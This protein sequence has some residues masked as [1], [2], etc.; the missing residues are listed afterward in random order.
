MTDPGW[1]DR[2]LATPFRDVPWDPADKPILVTKDRSWPIARLA[3]PVDTDV[4][5][6]VGIRDRE[7]PELARWLRAQAIRFY[8]MRVVDLTP[9]AAIQGLQHLCIA[10]NTKVQSIEPLRAFTDLRTLVLTNTPKVRSLA[11]LE[12]L[13]ALR[14]F[15]CSGF[16]FSGTGHTIDTLAPVSGL[17]LE[18]IRLTNC[19]VLDDGLRPLARIRTLR[20]LESSNQFETEDYAYL[21]VHLPQATCDKFAPYVRLPRPLEDGRDVMVVGRRKPFLNSQIDAARL[22][23]YEDRFRA[24]Q[25]QFASAIRP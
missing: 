10:W 22:R 2:L 17:S 21:S 6:V 20:G 25:R 9:L 1:I 4:A 14:A 7:L 16:A 11:P 18:E 12:S 15:E 8:E 19:A 3:E 5:Y 13:H 23:R 24:L